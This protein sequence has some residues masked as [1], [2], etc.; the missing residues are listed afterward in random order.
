MISHRKASSLQRL[1]AELSRAIACCRIAK[2]QESIAEKLSYLIVAERTS[3]KFIKLHLQ[4]KIPQSQS[5][6]EL[7]V[8]LEEALGGSADSF[9]R[10]D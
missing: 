6:M 4:G 7:M 2:L 5:I 9:L 3:A 10:Q 8:R 1:T